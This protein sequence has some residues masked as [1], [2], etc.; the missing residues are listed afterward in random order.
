MLPL[1]DQVVGVTANERVEIYQRAI[2]QVLVQMIK[3]DRMKMPEVQKQYQ[4][5]QGDL[6]KVATSRSFSVA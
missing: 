5:V 6:T 1:H 3:C 4:A 2:K